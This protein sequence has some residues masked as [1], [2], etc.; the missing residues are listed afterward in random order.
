MTGFGWV[1]TY[2]S[3][4]YSKFLII[5]IYLSFLYS[6]I[7]SAFQSCCVPLLS[8]PNSTFLMEIDFFTKS[9]FQIGVFLAQTISSFFFS[10]IHL[11]CLMVLKT[12]HFKQHNRGLYNLYCSQRLKRFTFTSRCKVNQIIYLPFITNN[13]MNR[14]HLFPFVNKIESGVYYK[15]SR[16]GGI[17]VLLARVVV[18]A[19]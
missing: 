14:L 15:S 3:F 4:S 5:R 19:L 18:Y 17:S 7:I 1:Q 8:F 9:R 10:T 13:L 6:S 11:Y 12:A 16:S 2:C